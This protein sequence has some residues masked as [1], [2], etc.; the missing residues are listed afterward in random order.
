MPSRSPAVTQTRALELLSVQ[1]KKRKITVTR[2]LFQVNTL[3]SGRST[4]FAE[5][6]SG[7]IVEYL[8]ETRKL[9]NFSLFIIIFHYIP[10]HQ[11]E[12]HSV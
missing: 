1:P 6:K 12:K 7:F 3:C 8:V 4:L 11:S 2:A 9:L 10:A 5:T